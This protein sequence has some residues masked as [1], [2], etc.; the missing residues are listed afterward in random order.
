MSLNGARYRVAIT[1]P[2]GT[3]VFSNPVT[4]TVNPL[5]LVTLSSVNTPVLLPNRTVTIN[6]TVSPTGGNYAWL[7]NG[8]P[9]SGASS[10]SLGPLRVENIGRYNLIYT[11]P[12]GC[13][14]TSSDFIVSLEV[15][16]YLWV[17]PNPNNGHFNVRYYNVTGEAVTLK[18]FDG[19][20][21]VVYA[22][23]IALGTAYSNIQVDMGSAAGG[24]YVVK[25][26]N[27][28]GAELN[29]KRIFVSH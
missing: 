9:I 24:W 23:A 15:T 10:P 2:C 1:G 3:V 28:S 7:L 25:I 19:L 18:V 29:A 22:Q 16:D 12:N 8:S 5:P 6:S 14:K 20:G 4:L 17:Y 27:G 26:M 21:Q 11:D 13:I